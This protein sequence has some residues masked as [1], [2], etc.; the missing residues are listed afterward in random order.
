M[1]RGRNSPSRARQCPICLRRVTTLALE[2]LS[3]LPYVPLEP[4]RLA[5]HVTDGQWCPGGGLIA[6]PAHWR[7][8]HTPAEVEA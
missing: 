2:E 4:R 5:N 6:T 7:E 8:T 1:S 3:D